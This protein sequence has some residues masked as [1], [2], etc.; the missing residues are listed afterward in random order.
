M[1]AHGKNWIYLWQIFWIFPD[2]RRVPGTP[3]YSPQ[4]WTKLPQELPP[5]HPIYLQDIREF[6]TKIKKVNFCLSLRQCQTCQY[7]LICT[8]WDRTGQFG[9]GGQA[10][11]AAPLSFPLTTL[12]YTTLHY[13]TL[14]YTTLHCTALH[15]TSLHYT[16]LHFTTLHY[17][18][19]GG[20]P[21]TDGP[22]R[23]GSPVN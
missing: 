6:G 22:T 20:P 13:T 4:Y 17:T 1:G 10:V 19:Q 2:S 15:F 11:L 12:H 7:L 18:T 16:T 9:T 21:K 5:N 23:A 14:L 8:H 3:G